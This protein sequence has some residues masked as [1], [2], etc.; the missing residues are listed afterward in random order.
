MLNELIANIRSSFDGFNPPAQEEKLAELLE[1]LG[2]VP[3]EV[4][5]LYRDHDGSVRLPRRQN[6]ELTAR[7]MPV[8]EA[9]RFRK[10]PVRF[11]EKIPKAGNW[12]CLWTDDNSN[13]CGIYTDG[14]LSGCVTVLDHEAP[15]LV[16][17]FRSI[18]SFLMRLLA[19]APNDDED[20]ARKSV[21]Y[22]IAQLTREIP[23]KIPDPNNSA[24]DRRLAALFKQLHSNEHN[25]DLRRLYAF[26]SICLTPFE[27]TGDVWSFVDD[28][29]WQVPVA[30][31][32]LMELRRYADAVEKLERL[33]H[34][35]GTHRGGAA[36]V[37]LARMDTS[38]S[39]EA[40][41]RLRKTLDGRPRDYLERLISPA[42]P[43]PE[44]R[45][46]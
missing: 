40:V 7:L 16:P 24:E 41:A 20:D 42:H 44:P 28:P 35:G 23:L 25:E 15:M 17:A 21:A 9:L 14:P 5:A 32:R 22:D 30:A 18:E 3:D 46:P 8:S 10:N 12:A 6:S 27:S 26:C 45:W 19:E 36:I 43:L 11:I 1:A 4:L 37:Y 34:E 39:Q 13:W 31:I 33:A 38:Q 2:G 29:D